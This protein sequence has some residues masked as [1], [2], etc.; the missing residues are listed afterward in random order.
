RQPPALLTVDSIQ[1]LLRGV[2][3]HPVERAMK[4]L[5][6]ICRRMEYFGHVQ[7]F[8]K[9]ALIPLGYAFNIDDCAGLVK[10][11]DRLHAF[12][13]RMMADRSWDLCISTDGVE[14]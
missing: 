4:L 10:H 6:A 5:S 12:D 14:L 9:R 11:L 3:R 8:S 2:P 7:R 1:E 13:Y